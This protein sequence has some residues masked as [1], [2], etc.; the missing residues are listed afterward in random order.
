M[1]YLPRGYS[2]D[3]DDVKWELWNLGRLPFSLGDLGWFPS[4]YLIPTIHS[5][6]V[7]GG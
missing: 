1:S 5:F 2:L 4:L 7:R 3:G 6:G